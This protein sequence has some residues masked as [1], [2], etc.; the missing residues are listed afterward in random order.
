MR[1]VVVIQLLGI[2]PNFWKMFNL[3]NEAQSQHTEFCWEYLHCVTIVAAGA[4]AVDV[5]H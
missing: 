5:V 4:A 2:F 3:R 1:N